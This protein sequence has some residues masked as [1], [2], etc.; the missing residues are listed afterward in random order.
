MPSINAQPIF[1][2][3][4]QVSLTENHEALKQQKALPVLPTVLQLSADFK[5]YVA[6]CHGRSHRQWHRA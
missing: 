6:G 3:K 1:A 2:P 4:P 5:A